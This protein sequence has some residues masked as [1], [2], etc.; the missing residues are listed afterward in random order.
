MTR[1]IG[2]DWNKGNVGRNDTQINELM[3]GHY[4]ISIIDSMVVA[5]LER[6]RRGL[7]SNSKSKSISSL[8]LG[9]RAKEGTLEKMIWP[10]PYRRRTRA[11]S[12]KQGLSSKE[13]SIN[14]DGILS[15]ESDESHTNTTSK[16]HLDNLLKLVFDSLQQKVD[17]QGKMDGLGLIDN[18]DSVYEIGAVKH[19]IESQSDVGHRLQLSEYKEK[20]SQTVF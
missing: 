8:C 19:V 6:N 5:S 10:M 15:L 12:T 13:K 18:D 4:I 16:K 3:L 11:S 1:V 14:S 7:F 20:N 9:R 2:M 17:T